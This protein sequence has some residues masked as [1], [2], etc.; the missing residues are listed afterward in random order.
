M[1]NHTL[2]LFKYTCRVFPSRNSR[3]SLGFSTLGIKWNW[4]PYSANYSRLDLKTVSYFLHPIPSRL[5]SYSG[6]NE[7]DIF[8]FF[9]YVIIPNFQKTPLMKM[10]FRSFDFTTLC[11]GLSLSLNAQI[12]CADPV[13]IY[14]FSDNG[15]NYEVIRENMD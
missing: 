9:N 7:F 12:Q 8:H 3:W 2:S 10:T 11:I 13:N 1:D 4:L 5:A 15:S 6:I 14:A